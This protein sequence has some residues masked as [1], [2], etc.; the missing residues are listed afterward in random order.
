MFLAAQV[1]E[2]SELA[3]ARY[4]PLSLAGKDDKMVGS[5]STEFSGKC[6][7]SA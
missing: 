2:E 4:R 1:P 6:V 5:G 7:T 3:V